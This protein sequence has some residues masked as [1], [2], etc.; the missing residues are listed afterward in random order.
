[1]LKKQLLIIAA[2][3][4]NTQAL[5]ADIKSD[6][7]RLIDWGEA[8]FYPFFSAGGQVSQDFIIDDVNSPFVGRWYYRFYP[9]TGAF[10][11][12]RNEQDI[13]V[14]GGAF[15]G[16][17]TLID[18]LEN[19][20][21]TLPAEG[22]CV[23]VAQPQQNTVAE[24]DINNIEE[25]IDNGRL[26]LTFKEFN[27]TRSVIENQ[28]ISEDKTI[29]ATETQIFEIKN[30]QLFL[31]KDSTVSDQT[32]IDI[33]S[34]F[35]YAPPILVSPVLEYCQGQSWQTNASTVTTTGRPA[36]VKISKGKTNAINIEITV[37]A[38]KFNTIK[39]TIVDEDGDKMESWIA[40]DSGLTI[41]KRESNKAG[42]LTFI[43][44]LKAIR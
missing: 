23:K 25:A 43:Q 19:L 26:V 14:L 9:Q 42:L 41:L 20:L 7:D 16:D 21:K 38:G 24:Y 15:G 31:T 11:A 18:S 29:T 3:L 40:I 1:M 4:F 32:L 30:N 8:S 2:L 5:K 44:T 28:I 12:L 36:P 22:S 34:T 13:Y 33:T 39:Q 10:I 17:L 37:S 27:S 6:T 35:E